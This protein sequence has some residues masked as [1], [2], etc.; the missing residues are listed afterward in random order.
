MTDAPAAPPIEDP[1]APVRFMNELVSIEYQIVTKPVARRFAKRLKEGAIT[2]HKCPSCAITRWRHD[3]GWT[4]N[5][6]AAVRRYHR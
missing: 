4:F 5:Q 1:N 2:G 3:F 6:Q